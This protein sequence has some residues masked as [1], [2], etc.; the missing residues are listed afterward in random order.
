NALIKGGGPGGCVAGSTVTDDGVLPTRAP[1]GLNVARD[2][3]V[4]EEQNANPGTAINL[5][6]CT[7]GTNVTLCP[8]SP[9]P[10]TVL[11]IATAGVGNSGTVQVCILGRCPIFF[12]NQSTRGDVAIPSTTV[13]G[14]M[15]DTGSPAGVAGY[16]FFVDTANAGAG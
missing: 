6:A 15:H 13:A 2:F 8:T 11:G 3:L 5:L 7:S 12:D 14:E 1:D 16:N 10:G 9:A 4:L